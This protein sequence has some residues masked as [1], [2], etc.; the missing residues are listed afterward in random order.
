MPSFRKM[1]GRCRIF[2]QLSE[3]ALLVWFRASPRRNQVTRPDRLCSRVPDGS[4]WPSRALCGSVQPPFPLSVAPALTFAFARSPRRRRARCASLPVVPEQALVLNCARWPARLP[5][6]RRAR[7]GPRQ[8]TQPGGAHDRARLAV[9][10]RQPF[11]PCRT[12]P[13]NAALPGFRPS[14]ELPFNDSAAG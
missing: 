6:A 10:Y 14:R 9:L 12:L 11:Q 1:L 5:R 7:S 13:R 2:L 4:S 3:H 8:R